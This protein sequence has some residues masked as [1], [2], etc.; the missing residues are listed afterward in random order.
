MVGASGFVGSA[1]CKAVSE[2]GHS[3]QQVRAPR[4]KHRSDTIPITEL[5]A[6]QAAVAGS[7]ALVN[8]A[9]VP[10]ASGGDLSQ[11]I[12]ANATLPR[13][14]AEVASTAGVRFI[15]VSSAAVQGRVPILD[16]R[17]DTSP[18]SPYSHSK[19][20][21][22][23]AALSYPE[24][25]VY[26]PPG[27]H[28]A[29]REVTKRLIKFA[30]S[31]LASVAKPGSANTA[32]AL[33]DN[34]AD[35]IAF[36][37]TTDASPPSIVSHPSEGLTVQ[38]LLEDLGGKSPLRLPRWFAR[39]IVGCAF[40][41]ACVRPGFAGIARRLEILWFG[42]EQAPSWLTAAGWTPPIARMG[43]REVAEI[44]RTQDKLENR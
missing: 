20:D 30:K 4:L 41:L 38:S 7:F 35:A 8:C 21:G 19:A 18:F 29:D 39:T 36:L 25:I 15:H 43:W 44:Y 42:Q 23:R 27:V 26:R 9:G 22:E 32:Q 14:L 31:R 40:H 34:V 10:D 3:V 1:V 2:R 33:L 6:I 24:T 13:L 5:A 28:G 37:A 16:A 17:T 12:P 11:L